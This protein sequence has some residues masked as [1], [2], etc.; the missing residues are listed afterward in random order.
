MVLQGVAL[1]PSLRNADLGLLRWNWNPRDDA[2]RAVTRL[3]GWTFGFVLANQIALFVVTIL[4][5]S[6][7]GPDPVSS[8]TYAYAF[9]Q[10]PY[11]IIAVT[12]M[13]VVT[14]DLAERWSTGQQ[15][16]FLKRMTGGLRAV[17]AL[18]IPAAV[19]MLLLAQPSV[20]L[21]LGNG[22]S[23]PA[24]TATTGAALAMFALG[25]PGFCTYLYLVRV[26]QSMQ[27]TR[28][29][30]YLYLVENALNIVLAL[31]LV[32]PLGVR[33]LALS[34]SIAYTVSAL[35]ALAVFH[36]WFGRLA[37]RET[38]APLV[39]VVIAAVPMAV[40]VLVVSNLSASTSIAG[41]LARVVG[42]V[43]AGGL[44]FGA[45]IIW[46]GRRHDAHRR[47]PDRP[48]RPDGPDGP[49]RTRRDRGARRRP[50]RP[51]TPAHPVGSLGH[52]AAPSVPSRWAPPGPPERRSSCP[53]RHL[54][55][56][57]RCMPGVHIVTDSAC[58]LT[59]QLVKEHNVIVVPLSIRFGNEELEDRRQ[60]T[61]AEFWERCR[62]KGDLPQTAAPSPGAFQAAFQQAADEGADAVL[63]LT[64]SSKVSG[65]YGSAV[66]AAD[67][68]TTVPVRVVDTYSLTMG[69]GLLVIAAAEE[70][71]AGAGLDDLVAA[72]EDRIPRTRIY[73]VLGGLEHLQRGGPRRR[74]PR[75]ARL[76]AQHQA[77][78]PAQG[79]RGGRGVQAADPQ[80]GARLPEGQGQ[81]RR[82][83]RAVRRGRRRLRRLQRRAGQPERHRHR[84]PDGLGGPRP[85]GRHP[86]RAR[87]RWASATSSLP[88]RPGPPGSLHAVAEN[89]LADALSDRALEA[90]DTVVATVNDKAIRPAIVAA[91]GI[92]FGVV[93]AVLG[94]TVVVLFC[95]GFIRLTTI[96]GHRIWASYLVLGLIFCAVGAVLYSRRGV[97]PD[98]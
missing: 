25:L 19:G 64:I 33:G 23:T 62:G 28:V 20:A 67:T 88:G 16:A 65:T 53:S 15:T 54:R 1:I 27:R 4:A 51:A 12:V 75:P 71:A 49:R 66:T 84:A 82:P 60:L 91:R 40:V 56:R 36:Q 22:H 52:R 90:V 11:G 83:A 50:V 47:P 57:L 97:P 73:G 2:L 26:L 32:H 79:R 5:G 9:F 31:V 17:L 7:A 39:R 92:V 80:Q 98:A 35:L 14:P 46:L 48:D 76:A 78:D 59:D 94:I 63:C 61:P 87:T 81:R 43:I 55:G 45:V 18:I 42:S 29:A 3:G 24:E 77:G 44:T 41:L 21:L 96:A 68:F 85:G 34:L 69:Q 37:E 6:V 13:S 38:W 95:V 10:L 8:Y 86:R 70:A 89:D 93:I 30:F 58:D 72:T 74:G